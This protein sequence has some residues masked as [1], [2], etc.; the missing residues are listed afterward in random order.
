[1]YH[2]TA[3]LLMMMATMSAVSSVTSSQNAMTKTSC[4]K[5][6][7][8]LVLVMSLCCLVSA[9]VCTDLNDEDADNPFW[10]ERAARRVHA[11]PVHILACCSVQ[12]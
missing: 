10:C 1:M 11:S 4:R 8:F 9:D 3:G 7:E 5:I 12:G 6:F 2:S